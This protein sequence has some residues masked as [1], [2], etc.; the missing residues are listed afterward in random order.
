[1]SPGTGLGHGSTFLQGIWTDKQLSEA[2]FCSGKGGDGNGWTHGHW[3]P[4]CKK[5]SLGPVATSP[6]RASRFL[7]T[8][9]ERR[10]EKP[11]A[12]YLSVVSRSGTHILSRF[13]PRSLVLSNN[14][15]ET[16]TWASAIQHQHMRSSYQQ[17]RQQYLKSQ[18]CA[19]F[20]LLHHLLH[21]LQEI[22]SLQPG[23]MSP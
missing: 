2:A 21:H 10:K 14:Q 18:E 7:G 23:P 19:L 15:Q 4:T 17:I 13:P 9:S 6:A 16:L 22:N 1:M 20:F 5:V 11:C 3:A 12:D 8:K